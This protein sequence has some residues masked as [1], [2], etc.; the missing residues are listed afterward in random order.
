[1]K[2]ITAA[3]V[4]MFIAFNATAQQRFFIGSDGDYSILI[5]Q[6]VTPKSL[7]PETGGYVD[8]YILRENNEFGFLLSIRK[9]GLASDPNF[10]FQEGFKKSFLDECE[11]E[12]L[13]SKKKNFR[14]FDG[15]QM[16]IKTALEGKSVKGYTVGAISSGILFNINFLA[17]ESKFDS[18]TPEFEKIMNTLVLR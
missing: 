8:Y 13:E 9:V 3:V 18:L 6:N 10:V 11:C 16:K 7:T 12:L 17:L 5:N 4:I 14:N 1:M 15:M 2:N